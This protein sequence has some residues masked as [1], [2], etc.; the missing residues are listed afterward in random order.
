VILRA[1]SWTPPRTRRLR[2]ETVRLPR[3]RALRMTAAAF[4]A[5]AIALGVLLGLSLAGNTAG[6]TF[7]AVPSAGIRGTLPS[8]WTTSSRAGGIALVS[9]DRSAV[10][11]IAAPAPAA[12]A[13]ALLNSTIAAIDREYTGARLIS[14]AMKS[15]AG[16]RGTVATLLARTRSGGTVHILLDTAAGRRVAY[17]VEVFT[18]TGAPTSTI[19]AAQEILD[20]LELT[21]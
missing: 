11:E 6:S 10:V 1:C 7:F 18:T 17:I 2:L 4:A 13:N 3:P 20:S 12:A 9:A 8:T 19:V 16:L 5:A 14:T 15:V 21:H